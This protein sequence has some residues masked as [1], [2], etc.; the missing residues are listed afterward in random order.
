MHRPP[1]R[2]PLRR[3]HAGGLGVLVPWAREAALFHGEDILRLR[4]LCARQLVGDF[5]AI[6]IRIAEIDAERDAVI[7]DMVDLDVL[8]L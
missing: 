8:L 6:A 1:E 2:F 5:Q 3:H 7:G 4:P